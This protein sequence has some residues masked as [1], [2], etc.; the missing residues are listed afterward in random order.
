MSWDEIYDVKKPAAG[1]NSRDS[2]M[3]KSR[4]QRFAGEKKYHI[5]AFNIGANLLKVLNWDEHTVLKFIWGKED[6]LGLL[7]IARILNRD[8]TGWSPKIQASS[9]LGVIK[10]KALPRG[11]VNEVERSVVLQHALRADERQ[12]GLLLLEVLLPQDFYIVGTQVACLE[13]GTSVPL[14]QLEPPA[15]S[16]SPPTPR[17]ET[18]APSVNPTPP[19]PGRQTSSSTRVRAESPLEPTDNAWMNVGGFIS[20]DQLCKYVRIALGDGA[21]I[22]DRNTIEFNGNRVS[23][24]V[25]LTYAN[26][27]RSKKTPKQPLFYL[28]N[29]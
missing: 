6:H 2:V 10:N 20:T 15:P 17:A 26:N 8:V 9:G 28:K 21:V 25:V 29:D 12:E 14:P 22:I 11:I 13:G 5:C 1:S 24:Q 23:A 3:L 16:V 19:A 4:D 18:P 27:A 7:R